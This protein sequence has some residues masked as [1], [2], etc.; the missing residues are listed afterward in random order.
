MEYPEALAVEVEGGEVAYTLQSLVVHSGT[1][2]GEGHYFALAR[3]RRLQVGRRI[4]T[5]WP[6]LHQVPRPARARGG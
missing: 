3:T 4:L 2:S 1:E 5:A 6:R